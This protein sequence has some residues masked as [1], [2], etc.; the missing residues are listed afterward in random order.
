MRLTAFSTVMLLC[1]ALSS[2]FK[3]EPLNAECD[4]E[5]AWLHSDNPEA[6]FFN[7][8]DSVVKVLYT[9]NTINFFVRKETNLKQL[10]PFFRTTEGATVVPASGSVQ[11][12]SSGAVQYKVTSED[13]QWSRTYSV[14]ITIQT[15]TVTDTLRY[16]FENY[17]LNDNNKY[18]VWREPQDEGTL[19]DLWASGNGG[20]AIS[21]SS[22]K[23]DEYPT[24]PELNGYD[25]A[26]VKLTTRDTGAFG[27]LKNMRIAAGN[28]FIGQFDVTQ[29]I[30]AGGAL[31]AT[32]FGQKYTATGKPVSFSGYYKYS[33]GATYQDV[34]GN[35]VAGKTDTGNIYAVLYKRFDSNGTETLLNGENVL[36]DARIVA[37]AVIDKVENV[38]E[39][40]R[41]DIP[42]TYLTDFDTTLLES[43]GYSFAVVFSSSSEGDKFEGAVGSTLYIDKVRIVCETTE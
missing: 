19:L 26:A 4:I 30:M 25:G 18:Y 2:C 9:D 39:W 41:F 35:A 38:S 12:F 11:D 29:A 14:N 34:N 17:S 32:M 8:A 21:R 1:L 3:D 37:T 31:K 10:A 40:T 28:L 20:F 7:M 15:R 23:A 42:F 24:T 5:E 27:K 22:A 36:T 43:Y 16:D 33:P 6:M 13:G